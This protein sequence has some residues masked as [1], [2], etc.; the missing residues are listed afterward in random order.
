MKFKGENMLKIIALSQVILIFVLSGCNHEKGLFGSKNT[1]KAQ[2]TQTQKQTPTPTGAQFVPLVTAT[3]S[4]V[5]S[6]GKLLDSQTLAQSD[7]PFNLAVKSVEEDIKQWLSRASEVSPIGLKMPAQ[8]DIP[9]ANILSKGE[10]ETTKQFQT[11][12]TNE[13]KRYNVIKKSIKKDYL[14]Q[15]NLYNIA[16]TEYNNEIQWEQRKRREQI[17]SIRPQLL[18]TAVHNVLGTPKIASIQYNAD[19]EIFTAKIIASN[20]RVAYDVFIPVALSEA[21][22]FKQ[23][24]NDAKVVITMNIDGGKIRPVSFKINNAQASYDAYLSNNQ[25][26]STKQRSAGVDDVDFSD[27][28]IEKPDDIDV[29]SILNNNEKF[30]QDLL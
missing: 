2:N 21:K 26:I 16:V 1:V 18:R 30:F 4:K 28:I 19:K 14:N 25:N 13:R 8:S 24:A 15:V 6:I 20:S 11:R 27:A 9:P 12:L 29:E 5:F 23:N 7:A 3:K 17:A 10:F 22:L